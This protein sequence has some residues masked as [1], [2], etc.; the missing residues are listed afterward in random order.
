MATLAGVEVN[1]DHD[2]AS[3]QA[4]LVLV[5]G[6]DGTL[7]SVVRRLQGRQIPVMGTNFGRISFG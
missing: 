7:L 6:G 2:L 3:I 1:C 4:D 5:L